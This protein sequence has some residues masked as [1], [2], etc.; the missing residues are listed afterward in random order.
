MKHKLAHP[1]RCFTVPKL[2]TK[3]K[4]SFSQQEEPLK[5]A[6][7]K[8]PS[9]TRHADRLAGRQANSVSILL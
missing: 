9:Q 2:A 4:S 5:E 8:K 7:T 6:T 3:K 1:V